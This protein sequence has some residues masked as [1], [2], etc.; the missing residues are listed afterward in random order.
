MRQQP[1]RLFC[2]SLTLLGGLLIVAGC[3]STGSLSSSLKR[4]GTIQVP[5]PPTDGGELVS[6]KSSAPSTATAQ[7][8]EQ[9]ANPPKAD[10]GVRPTA[11]QAPPANLGPP[12]EI[13][14]KEMPAQGK[15]IFQ[16]GG[17]HHGQP[18]VAL[19]GSHGIE[20]GAA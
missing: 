4:D 20:P 3:Q 7:T 12:P 19:P 16:P 10:S 13:V 2:L 18:M 5:D 9:W 1:A 11:F 17:P 14:V 6:W 15:G 8:Q